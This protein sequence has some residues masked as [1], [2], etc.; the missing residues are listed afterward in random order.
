M[1]DHG[2]APGRQA[3]PARRGARLA[4]ASAAPPRNRAA[5]SGDAA[6]ATVAP[7]LVGAALL[8]GLLAAGPLSCSGDHD[9][10]G[11]TDAAS[12]S[13]GQGAAGGE[14]GAAESSASQGSGAAGGGGAG[15]VGPTR[16]TLVN[17]IVNADEVKLCAL[18]YPGG[19][20]ADAPAWPSDPLA[21]G[22]ARVV[23]P[24]GELLPA[25]VD[26]RVH[27]LT[28]DL[29]LVD[30][31]SCGALV[32]VPASGAGGAGGAGGAPSG[33]AGGGGPVPGVLVTA[34]PVIPASAFESGK[35]VLLVT[36]GCVAGLEGS[37]AK[38]ACGDAY[39]A[40]S[41]TAT[42]VAVGMDEDSSFD[43][44]GLQAVH[45][46][47]ATP[48]VDVRVAPGTASGVTQ[49]L[50][51]FLGFGAIGPSPAYASLDEMGYG[52]LN[53]VGFPIHQPGDT[54]L[55]LDELPLDEALA[56]GGLVTADFG[57]GANLVMVAVGAAPGVAGTAAF[58]ALSLTAVRATPE[59]R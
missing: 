22:G 24:L 36:A 38:V 30:G 3:P 7:L 45:A 55:P 47:V 17:G 1:R 39:Q 58:H 19:E 43:R 52:T 13:T 10:L 14:G 18:G 57:D 25:E 16:L 35:S 44:V 41:P 56:R 49:L 11:L 2:L 21:F 12:S 28:G 26:V 29:S 53:E 27:V 5:R 40:R 9:D 20:G 48:V 46:S 6:H 51:T 4:P 42:L 23:D 59:T 32:G 33:G 31:I 54:Q 34:L 15:P 8:A 37:S 50:A